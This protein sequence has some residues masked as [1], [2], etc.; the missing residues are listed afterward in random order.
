MT[1]IKTLL[2]HIDYHAE[3][4]R[5]WPNGS[6][7]PLKVFPLE[8]C[9]AV[10]PKKTRMLA[11]PEDVRS[12]RH[13]HNR[14][15]TVRA[16]DRQRYR[17][18]DTQTDGQKCNINIARHLPMRDKNESTVQTD[19]CTCKQT[20]IDE[21]TKSGDPASQKSRQLWQVYFR[22]AWDNAAFPL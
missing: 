3:F 21:Q 6:T 1:L 11:H 22:Q 14:L 13:I 5:W 20:A 16:L 12:L 15:D 9:K 4:D 7:L 17:R 10:R 18:T 19:K 8:Y 2:L